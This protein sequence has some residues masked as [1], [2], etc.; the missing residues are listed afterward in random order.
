M[1]E[2]NKGNDWP[3]SMVSEQSGQMT[4]QNKPSK[5]SKVSY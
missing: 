2:A 4:R 3:M 1:L 5:V